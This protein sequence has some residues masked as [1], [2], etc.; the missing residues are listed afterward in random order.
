MTKGTEWKDILC[1]NP[2]RSL[3]HTVTI[4]ESV[5][6][7]QKDIRERRFYGSWVENLIIIILPLNWWRRKETVLGRLSSELVP[8]D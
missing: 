6:P 7:P 3:T 8:V 2:K 4:D 1:I 5:C